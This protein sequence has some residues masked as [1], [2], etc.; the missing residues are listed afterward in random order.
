MSV[1]SR[2]ERAFGASGRGRGGR[3]RGRSGFGLYGGSGS[4]RDGRRRSLDGLRRGER[5]RLVDGLLDLVEAVRLR[6][7]G[8][9]LLERLDPVVGLAREDQI[10]GLRELGVLGHRDLVLLRARVALQH[11]L[12]RI[13][14]GRGLVGA[15]HGRD[16]AHA[17]VL[18]LALD[19]RLRERLLQVPEKRH[20][21]LRRRRRRL[22]V[23]ESGSG[24]QQRGQRGGTFA[25]FM[26]SSLRFLPSRGSA[27]QAVDIGLVAVESATAF[28]PYSR[29][30]SAFLSLTSVFARFSQTSPSAASASA[31]FRKSCSA[32]A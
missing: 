18:A 20:D 25:I 19:G 12:V 29:A 32:P 13:G 5:L 28:A 16:A 30:L 8:L 24:Q 27:G 21:G 23:G 7:L 26:S 9:E 17:V 1:I 10:H 22:L 3:G 2:P 15:A 4:R 31:A 14:Q 6:M 11:G